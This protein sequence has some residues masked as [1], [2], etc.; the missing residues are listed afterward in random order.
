MKFFGMIS[1]HTNEACVIICI[2]H[3]YQ[4]VDGA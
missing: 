2:T 3:L 1:Q 4:E